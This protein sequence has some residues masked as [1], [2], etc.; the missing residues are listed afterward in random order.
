VLHKHTQAYELVQT[1]NIVMLSNE[2]WNIILTLQAAAKN[3]LA[4]WQLLCTAQKS[5]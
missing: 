4:Q 1:L 2:I 3:N 5:E